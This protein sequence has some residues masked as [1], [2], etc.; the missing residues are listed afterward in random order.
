LEK[1]KAK[2]ESI[3]TIGKNI[4]NFSFDALFNCRSLGSLYVSLVKTPFK[5][6]KALQSFAFLVFTFN[7]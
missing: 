1:L 4:A 6:L 5:E 2:I 7:N 3:L